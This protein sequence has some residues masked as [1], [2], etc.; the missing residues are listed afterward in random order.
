MP[1]T[2]KR[3]SRTKNVAELRKLAGRLSANDLG[4]ASILLSQAIL[5]LHRRAGEREPS[6]SCRELLNLADQFKQASLHY[7]R[8]HQIQAL[9]QQLAAASSER[10]R[11]SIEA[12]IAR[13]KTPHSNSRVPDTLQAAIDI[14][15]RDALLAQLHRSATEED[16]SRAHARIH[17]LDQRISQ[18][19]AATNAASGQL[20]GDVETGAESH[21]AVDSESEERA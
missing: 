21:C 6:E 4:E 12:T 5:E 10:E 17:E 16:R 8:L 3:G 19:S 9:T 1:T 15:Q 18:R 11:A 7:S 20:D 2:K 13:L 14:K